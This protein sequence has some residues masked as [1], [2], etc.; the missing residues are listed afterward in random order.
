MSWLPLEYPLESEATLE[1]AEEC[2]TSMMAPSKV[3]HSPIFEW[4]PGMLARQVE[5]EGT[6]KCM[7]HNGFN[8]EHAEQSG[9]EHVP[10]LIDYATKAALLELIRRQGYPHAHCRI[11]KDRFMRKRWVVQYLDKHIGLDCERFLG[12]GNT[13]SQAITS[14]FLH[15]SLLAVEG[16]HAC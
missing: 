3:R 12:F 9:Y 14:A 2:F 6:V 15:V 16:I 8:V 1:Q 7:R 10:V 13:Q 11:D 4:M 5:H